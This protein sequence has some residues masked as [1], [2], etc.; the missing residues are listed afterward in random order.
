LG[1]NPYRQVGFLTPAAIYFADQVTISAIGPSAVVLNLLLGRYILKE[2][3]R[4]LS[5]IA[6]VFLI[7]G[8]VL[9]V[10]FSNYEKVKYT[11][12]DIEHFFL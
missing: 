4:L 8:S 12:F 11:I 9:G 5:Y 2:K 3:V 7:A 6:C 10:V 1:L